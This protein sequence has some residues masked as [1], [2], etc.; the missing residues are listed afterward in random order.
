ML[1]FAVAFVT[2]FTR[3]SDIVPDKPDPNVLSQRP[4]EDS[5]DIYKGF[6]KQLGAGSAERKES[7]EKPLWQDNISFIIK[8]DQNKTSPILNIAAT[9]QN[10]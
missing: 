5:S 9:V 2:A 6:Y 3:S 10:P 1:F 4:F 7:E 8:L